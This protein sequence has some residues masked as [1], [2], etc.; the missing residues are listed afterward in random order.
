MKRTRK[1]KRNQL[2]YGA[3]GLK[4]AELQALK[5]RFQEVNDCIA[6]AQMQPTQIW[7]PS[8]FTWIN[9]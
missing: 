9:P 5:E 6:H 7:I 3:L 8:F 4:T 2:L 1:K